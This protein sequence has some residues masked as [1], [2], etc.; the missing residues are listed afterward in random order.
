M[1][2]QD[3]EFAYLRQTTLGAIITGKKMQIDFCKQ[4][5]RGLSYHVSA[6]PLSISTIGAFTSSCRL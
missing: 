6:K 1:E 3:Q 2:K 5:A 4:I